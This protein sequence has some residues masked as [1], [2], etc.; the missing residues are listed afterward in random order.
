MATRE[1]ALKALAI[2]SAAYPNFNFPEASVN[3]YIL[4]LEDIPDTVLGLA[5]QRHRATSKWFPSIS[6]LR[7]IS[8]RLMSGATNLPPALSAWASFNRKLR[9]LSYYEKPDF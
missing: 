3:L 7:E 6:E 1:Y 5:C 9:S 2:L 8:A 4:D